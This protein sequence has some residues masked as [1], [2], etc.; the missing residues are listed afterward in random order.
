MENG[1]GFAS[2]SRVG[3]LVRHALDDNKGFGDQVL[4]FEFPDILLDRRQRGFDS[5]LP[6]SAAFSC[7]SLRY[8]SRRT[9]SGSAAFSFVVSVL[10]PRT[11]Q[12]LHPRK[13]HCRQDWRIRHRQRHRDRQTK[14]ARRQVQS[15][16]SLAS[17]RVNVPGP[18][19][20]APWPPPP[21]ARSIRR[22]PKREKSNRRV[23]RRVSS[24]EAVRSWR[25]ECSKRTSFASFSPQSALIA[26]QH[27]C[28]EKVAEGNSVRHEGCLDCRRI[29]QS[30]CRV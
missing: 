8:S 27:N 24:G 4:G 30:L 23:E 29:K 25:H 6:I 11:E 13:V 22:R 3:V 17:L 7:I 10:P 1:G 9:A 2:G 14:S 20:V 5:A 26:Q 12:M 19:G 28:G 18:A 21:R 16:H 15:S